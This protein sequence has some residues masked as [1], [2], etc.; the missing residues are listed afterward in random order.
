M[1]PK[2]NG[3]MQREWGWLIAIYLFLGG[4]GG[5][6]Y[7]I[8]AINS[9]LGREAGAVHDGRPVDRLPGPAHRQPLPDGRPGLA[10]PGPSWPA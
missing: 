6:A 3:Q 8:A 1:D 10:R 2:V 7:T 5:G 4:V 9:F